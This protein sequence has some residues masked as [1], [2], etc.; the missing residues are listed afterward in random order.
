MQSDMVS[1]YNL[2]LYPAKFPP[3][4]PSPS[5]GWGLQGMNK[6]CADPCPGGARIL[7]GERDVTQ[8]ISKLREEE[9]KE[10]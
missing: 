10:N 3:V 4:G 6:T 2:Q 8:Q 1:G 9:K 5:L 7:S